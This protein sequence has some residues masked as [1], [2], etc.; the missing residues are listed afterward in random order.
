M[1]QDHSPSFV[2]MSLTVSGLMHLAKEYKESALL[3]HKQPGRPRTY[4]FH[5]LS[6]LSTELY[7]KSLYAFAVCLAHKD[8][9]VIT[10]ESISLEI[11]AKLGEYK[12]N[13]KM[14]IDEQPRLKTDLGITSILDCKNGRVDQYE[15][16]RGG[17][18]LIIKSLMAV[19]YGLLAHNK[20]NGTLA[21]YDE[22]LIKFLGELDIY[23]TKQQEIVISKLKE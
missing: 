18:Y 11:K 16:K 15:I 2:T 22:S 3:I 17:D 8:D 1:Q 14:L 21:I 7:L 20:D 9:Y 10:N 4:T 13:I 5:L 19:R 23:V 6:S 12:H